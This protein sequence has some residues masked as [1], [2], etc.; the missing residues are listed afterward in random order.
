MV[1]WTKRD[2]LLDAF[3]TGLSV[4]KACEYAGVAQSTFFDEQV[5]S[6]EFADQIARA[7][8]RS[9]SQAIKLIQRA[10]TD[11]WR[12]AE[13]YLKLTDP[14]E[15]GDRLNLRSTHRVEIVNTILVAIG[16]AFDL[17]ITDPT[18]RLR[19]TEAIGTRVAAALG[20]S[21][22]PEVRALPPHVAD[23]VEPG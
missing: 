9:E 19:L 21:G 4:K 16:E 1:M 5:R 13:A 20:G 8:V 22:D 11:D 7:R 23:M 15:Y 10:G 12:A 18:L 3:R 14:D 2:A 17:V 6:P